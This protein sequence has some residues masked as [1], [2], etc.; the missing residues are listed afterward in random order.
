MCFA[1]DSIQDYHRLSC[2]HYRDSRRVP[3]V[4]KVFVLRRGD[5]L[6][7]V[8]LYNYPAVHTQ[9][10]KDAFG[11]SL[12]IQEI[13][14]CLTTIAKVVIHPKYR[15]IGLGV[16]LV[17]ETLPLACKPYVET[18]AV[19]SKYNPFFERAGMK[20]ILESKPNPAVLEA[21]EKLRKLGFNPVF[22]SSEKYNM[23]Q[24]QA[25]RS[26]SQVKTILKDLSKAVGIYLK[27]LWSSH[28]AYM[29]KEEFNNCVD[30]A[31]LEKLARMLRILGFLTQTKVYLFW[32]NVEE[33]DNPV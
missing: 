12:S 16:K 32:K 24:L 29:L 2:F 15:T 5:G 17:R 26:G 18:V 9:G 23:H 25:L 19:M 30:K 6:C 4:Q 1:E 11:R 13:N 8:I 10:R 27:R 22:L 7:G 14:R 3:A 28:K 33:A 31:S 21:V 20:K